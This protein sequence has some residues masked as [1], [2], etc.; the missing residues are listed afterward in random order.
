VSARPEKSQVGVVEVGDYLLEIGD[1]AGI[2]IERSEAS[3]AGDSDS[4]SGLSD[5]LAREPAPP[6]EEPAPTEAA[7]GLVDEASAV[8]GKVEQA[9]ALGKGLSAGEALDP[10][11]VGLELNVA[12]N[13]LEKLDRSGKWKEELRLARALADLYGLL[14]RWSDL[15]RSLRAV[16]HAGE[17]LGDLRAIGWAKH[18]LGTLEVVAGGVGGAARNLGEAREIRQRAGSEREVELTDRSLRALCRQMNRGSFEDKHRSILRISVPL[19][20]LAALLL[21]FAGGIAGGVVGHRTASGGSGGKDGEGK[22]VGEIGPHGK[23]LQVRVDGKGTI[24]SDPAG[25]ECPSDC[26]EAFRDGERVTL[27]ARSAADSTFSRFS[28]DCEGPSPCELRLTGS[29]T[30]KAIFTSAATL[31]I[32][33]TGEGGASATAETT[34]ISLSCHNDRN[35]VGE[36]EERLPRASESCSESF[37]TDTAVVVSVEPGRGWH[38]ESLDGCD[39]AEA[40]TCVVTLSSSRT[41]DVVFAP[42]GPS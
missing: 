35:E 6:E 25:I 10:A 29:R 16:L 24:V 2:A 23:V 9:V 37:P 12:L 7:A 22:E 30:V 38:R 34:S 27:T 41:V 32:N 18:Q 3:G 17:A 8:T 26:A 4:L 36:D 1:P 33:V 39:E 42:T 13:L 40:E 11:Q 20:V 15:L 19:A 28:G 21:L 5:A 14:R 31:T